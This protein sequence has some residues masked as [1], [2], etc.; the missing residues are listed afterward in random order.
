MP[1]VSFREWKDQLRAIMREEGDDET[2]F[3][4]ALSSNYW[5]EG[6]SPRAFYKEILAGDAA[7]R[8]TEDFDIR[9][10]L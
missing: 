6:Y 9:Y 3:D 5:R 7:D 1:K 4:A 10:D 2:D 8:Q